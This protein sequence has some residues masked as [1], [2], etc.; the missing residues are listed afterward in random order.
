MANKD[1]LSEAKR[2][3]AREERVRILEQLASDNWIALPRDPYGRQV[4]EKTIAVVRAVISELPL[5]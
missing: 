5:G 3:G 4:A 2:E 1:E